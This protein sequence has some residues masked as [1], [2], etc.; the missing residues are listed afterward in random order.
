MV[1]VA[2]GRAGR[3]ASAGPE[4]MACLQQKRSFTLETVQDFELNLK[5]ELDLIT[6]KQIGLRGDVKTKTRGFACCLIVL[7]NKLDHIERFQPPSGFQPEITKGIFN[8][9]DL[10]L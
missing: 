7:E 9:L 6:M 8:D 5:G 1:F 3:S 2:Q 10:F 4:A